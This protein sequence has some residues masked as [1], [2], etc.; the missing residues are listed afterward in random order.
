MFTPNPVVRRIQYLKK[1]DVEGLEGSLQD[2]FAYLNQFR[3]LRGG[4]LL[5]QCRVIQCIFKSALGLVTTCNLLLYTKILQV[6][7]DSIVI[8]KIL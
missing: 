4:I 6:R 7:H 2:I 5:E 1:K 8:K 3:G